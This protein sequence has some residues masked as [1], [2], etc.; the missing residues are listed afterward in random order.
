MSLHWNSAADCIFPEY[1]YRH[2]LNLLVEGNPFKFSSGIGLIYLFKPVLIKNLKG[3]DASSKI[4]RWTKIF[5]KLV[6]VPLC[7]MICQ[8]QCHNHE[9]MVLN[10]LSVMNLGLIWPQCHQAWYAI[11]KSYPKEW[12]TVYRGGWCSFSKPV[13]PTTVLGA[14]KLNCRSCKAGRLTLV[15]TRKDNGSS[16]QL[17]PNRISPLRRKVQLPSQYYN[18][19]LNISPRNAIRWGSILYSPIIFLLLLELSEYPTLS[20]SKMIP[21]V[22]VSTLELQPN[23]NAKARSAKTVALNSSCKPRPWKRYN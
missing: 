20:E 6:L 23:T 9:E 13:S 11:R 10:D 16:D 5:I 2:P 19:L 12:L 17:F 1:P 15:A 21:A 4:M 7:F 14:S 3:K 22:Y 18:T 8:C